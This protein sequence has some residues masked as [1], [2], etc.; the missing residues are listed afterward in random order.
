KKAAAAVAIRS[1]VCREEFDRN[2]P[3][4]APIPRAIDSTHSAFADFVEDFVME[5]RGTGHY[6]ERSSPWQSRS[7]GIITTAARIYWRFR[8]SRT[9]S[10]GCPKCSE[11]AVALA[12]TQDSPV[13]LGVMPNGLMDHF[14]LALRFSS[15][16]LIHQALMVAGLGQ[17]LLIA[18]PARRFEF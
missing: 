1:R 8:R 3:I 18:G 7:H 17:Q 13:V 15:R 14:P 9:L 12:E 10:P 4:Q 11:G 5:E 16:T 2:D 6:C